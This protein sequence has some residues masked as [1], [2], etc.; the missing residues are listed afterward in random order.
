MI[1]IIDERASGKTSRL[2]LLAKET[3]CTIA[4]HNPEDLREK[5]YYYG[6]TGLDIISYRDLLKGS[7]GTPIPPNVL[8]DELELFASYVVASYHRKLVGYTLSK[9]N[10]K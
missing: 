3:G 10:S 7:Y 1:Q 8:I 9:E 5:A 6:I 2:L 4:C